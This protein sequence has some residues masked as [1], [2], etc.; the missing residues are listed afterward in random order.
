MIVGV[1]TERIRLV[2]S[3][4]VT[5][6]IVRRFPDILEGLLLQS[7]RLCDLAIAVCVFRRHRVASGVHRVALLVRD[8]Q[9]FWVLCRRV[10]L[11]DPVV[12]SR[13]VVAL[14]IHVRF[15]L[16]D[17][18]SRLDRSGCCRKRDAVVTLGESDR[19]DRLVRLRL[20]LFFL[21][22]ARREG[23]NI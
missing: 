11:A 21:F 10:G 12:A 15:A 6:C 1:A 8:P 18:R 3:G 9:L 20:S 13:S 4:W 17:W 14:T 19:S 16:C 5:S 23:V 2:G 22:T 7:L